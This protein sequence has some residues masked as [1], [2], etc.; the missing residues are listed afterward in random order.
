MQAH[1]TA[2]KSGENTTPS[3]ISLINYAVFLFNNNYE[4]NR[5]KIIEIMMEFEKCWLKRKNGNE[6]D[7]NIMN[8]ATALAEQLNLNTHLSWL[9]SNKDQ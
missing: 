8:T 6:F 5:E 3:A 2:C 1:E 4:S 9:K 7:E